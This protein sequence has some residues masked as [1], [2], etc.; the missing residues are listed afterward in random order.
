MSITSTSSFPTPPPLPPE[1]PAVVPPKSPAIHPTFILS[2]IF[3]ATENQSP[4]DKI[5]RLATRILNLNSIHRLFFLGDVKSKQ[6]PGK[7]HFLTARAHYLRRR[8]AVALDQLDL[9]HREIDDALDRTHLECMAR[10]LDVV[11]SYKLGEF[12]RALRGLDRITT[13]SGGVYSLEIKVWAHLQKA[14]CYLGINPYTESVQAFD[15]IEKGDLLIDDL[16]EAATD[17]GKIDRSMR[18]PYSLTKTILYVFERE[19]YLASCTLDIAGKCN[20]KSRLVNRFRTEFPCLREDFPT[21]L[22]EEIFSECE[23]T[24]LLDVTHATGILEGPLL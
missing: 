20:P 5:A 7:V 17:W 11:C 13:D 24:D 10:V 19:T 2:A 1:C 8:Y 23:L 22:F 3:Q 9:Y 16:E 12:E 21:E 6:A 18:F 15:S 14:L 4:E